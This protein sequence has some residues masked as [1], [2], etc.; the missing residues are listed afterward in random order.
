M[1]LR[2]GAYFSL[3]TIFASVYNEDNL[4]IE[5]VEENSFGSRYWT[6]RIGSDGREPR[7]EHR[8]PRV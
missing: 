7:A 1:E 4:Q 2:G 5:L 8:E 3:D 6:H